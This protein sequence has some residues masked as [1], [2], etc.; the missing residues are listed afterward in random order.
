[1]RNRNSTPGLVRR[2]EKENEEATNYTRLPI[3]G[4]GQYIK[5]S[6]KRRV[7]LAP[8]LAFKRG[9]SHCSRCLLQ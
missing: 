7:L 4:A 3:V 5:R 2:L 8:T 9:I 6:L 1:M